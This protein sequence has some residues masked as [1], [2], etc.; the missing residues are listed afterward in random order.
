MFSYFTE[1]NRKRPPASLLD[2]VSF[3]TSPMVHAGDDR[4]VMETR[5]AY[6]AIIKT[7]A[8]IAKAT[9]WAVG[10]SAI[11]MRDNPYGETAKA[12][13]DNIRQAMNGNDPRQRGLFGAAWNLGYFADFASGGAAAI[14]L[15]AA[16]GPFG[17]V[18]LD[19]DFAPDGFAGGIYPAF[20]VLRGLARLR[21][22]PIRR[23]DLDPSGP[24][25]A[26][27]A[28]TVDGIEIWVANTCP[29]PTEI[30]VPAPAQ[31]AILNV[32]TFSRA[33]ADPVFMDKLHALQ[34]PLSLDAFA[35]ARILIGH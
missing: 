35:V 31:G 33:A 20:H 18:A 29:T 1:L 10:P 21:S 32:V 8:Q 14:A 15:G 13:P 12:N 3:T 24:V 2:L 7:V 25:T 9:P 34:S 6:P 11:G 5:E 23:L 28:E 16:A 27:A 4:S 17:L 22:A 26:L 19:A 30:V